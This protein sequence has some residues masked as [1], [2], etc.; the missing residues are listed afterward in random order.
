MALFGSLSTVKIQSNLARTHPAA[1]AYLAEALTPGSAIH[2]RLLALPAGGTERIEL[3]EGIFVLEQAYLPKARSD[4]R[5]EA[6]RAYIDLQAIVTGNEVM[7]TIDVSRLRVSEDLTPGK[8]LIFFDDAPGATVLRVVAGDVAVIH[9]A[10]AHM[11][12]LADGVPA[13]VR[14]AVVKVPVSG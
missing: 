11:P 1:F 3:G 7:E 14:K 8:D 12:S 4:G 2:Q 9:P 6:H 5:F 13:L 10:D